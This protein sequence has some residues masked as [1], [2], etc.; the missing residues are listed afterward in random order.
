[1]KRVLNFVIIFLFLFSVL[2][3]PATPNANKRESIEEANNLVSA[4]TGFFE[5][6]FSQ[7]S[8]T[9]E[10]IVRNKL[11]TE[12]GGSKTLPGEVAGKCVCID[13]G[14]QAR[15]NLNLEPI[16]PRS[17]R[18]KEKCKGGARGVSSGVPEYR[19]TLQIAFKLK[20]L[21]GRSGVVVV[22]TRE[23][24]NVNISNIER[25][26]IANRVGAD[27]F[28]RIHCDGSNDPSVSGITTF[29]PARNQWT[30]SIYLESLRSAGLVQRE[31]VKSCNCRNNGIVPRSDFTGFNW[32]KVPVILVEAGFLTNP[33]EDR[34]LNS[35]EYQWKVAEGIHYG[36]VRYFTGEH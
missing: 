11:D 15:G 16:A 3:I 34:L 1:M 6:K 2:S 17:S 30:E 10:S 31:L 32:S 25:A 14:H 13:P 35:E 29:Y 28:V 26:T 7:V 27:L 23:T 5:E 20:N 22:M 9:I 21:L 33:E 24:D 36:V 18:M 4:I 8:E 12:A 19:I